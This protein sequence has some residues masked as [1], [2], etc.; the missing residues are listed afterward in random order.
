MTYFMPCIYICITN[1]PAYVCRRIFFW[2]ASRPGLYGSWP[3][4]YIH[5]QTDR[6]GHCHCRREEGPPTSCDPRTNIGISELTDVDS[7]HKPQA[8][9]LPWRKR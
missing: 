4:F 7:S 1:P 8:V 5:R 2:A 9:Y 6:D 3:G